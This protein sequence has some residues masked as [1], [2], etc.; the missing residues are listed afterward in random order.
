MRYA[1]FVILLALAGFVASAA[2][3]SQNDFSGTWTMDPSRSE[4]AH[5]D[6]PVGSSTMV[7]R[8][9]DG[10]LA[11]ET[12]RGEEGK[13]AAFHETL[14]FKLGGPETT[15][16]GD[17]GTPVTGKARW[18][19]TKLVVETARSIQGSTVTTLY[20]HTLS[21]DGREMTIDKTLTIQHGYQGVGARTS[22][23][24]KDIFVRVA[25]KQD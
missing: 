10:G 1:G 13:P 14:N 7:I 21:A 8:V 22:G 24:G 19:G 25:K 11:I 9:A 15:S 4:S 17:G 12:I 20:V 6:V 16:Q 3:Q 23:H 2:A 5:Q 18:E